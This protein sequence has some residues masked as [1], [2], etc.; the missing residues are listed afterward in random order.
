MDAPTQ[1]PTAQP[2][3]V[4]GAEAKPTVLN[5]QNHSGLHRVLQTTHRFLPRG[6]VRSHSEAV[7]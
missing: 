3:V 4:A 5:V 7:D 2:Q 1:W 6:T